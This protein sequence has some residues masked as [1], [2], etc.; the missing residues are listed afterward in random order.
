LL[1]S[2]HTDN[3]LVGTLLEKLGCLRD[4]G[5]SEWVVYLC[6][7]VAAFDGSALLTALP[8]FS[9]PPAIDDLDAWALPA[10]TNVAAPFGATL[11]PSPTGFDLIAFR[12]SA[13]TAFD[14][15][16]VGAAPVVHLTW[17]FGL[18][19]PLLL[20]D[21][22]APLP[23]PLFLVKHVDGWGGALKLHDAPLVL[24]TGDRLS[25]TA[26]RRSI[27]RLPRGALRFECRFT[28]PLSLSYFGAGL[29][30]L[31]VDTASINVGFGDSAT[32]LD[33]T[34]I[35]IYL[36]DPAPPHAW[37]N[38][39]V[40]M[41]PIT[42]PVADSLP[43]LV[44][45]TSPANAGA[46]VAGQPVPPPLV[47]GL[48]LA[49][50]GW[51]DTGGA[52]G[53]LTGPPLLQFEPNTPIPSTSEIR[54]GLVFNPAI[55]DDPTTRV[56]DPS[57]FPGL[58][59]LVD[60]Q[61]RFSQIVGADL[62]LSDLVGPGAGIGL[63]LSSLPLQRIGLQ[64]TAG[65]QVI[66]PVGVTVGGGP[67]G[68]LAVVLCLELDRGSFR[69]LT[70][71]RRISFYLMPDRDDHRIQVLDLKALAIGIPT[72]DDV[73]F[74][75]LAPSGTIDAD[76]FLDSVTA[77]F[78]LLDR[79]TV[80]VPRLK[81]WIIFPGV[82]PVEVEGNNA[83]NSGLDQRL[84]L[85]LA[86]FDVGAYQRDH[87]LAGIP[88]ALLA[89]GREGITFQA[90]LAT[91]QSISLLDAT[92]SLR[93]VELRALPHAANDPNDASE[94][95]FI[96]NRI[97]KAK[98]FFEVD[99]PG[100][101]NV[102]IT[103][104]LELRPSQRGHAPE[105]VA[106]FDVQD[107][108]PPITGKLS[109]G[110]LRAQLTRVCPRLSWDNGQWSVSMPAW[111]YFSVADGVD[112][113]AAGT[114][115][116]EAKLTFEALDLVT[117][118]SESVQLSLAKRNPA[119]NFALLGGKLRCRIRELALDWTLGSNRSLTIDCH[120]VSFDVASE[121]G[122]SVGFDTGRLQFTI[123]PGLHMSAIFSE[124]I[125]LHVALS[126]TFAFV[127]QAIYNRPSA[128]IP[129]GEI[130]ARGS[131]GVGGIDVT[132]ILALA[133]VKKRG[134]ARQLAVVVGGGEVV[135]KQ[136]APVLSV[137][138]FLVGIAVNYRLKGISAHPN[139]TELVRNIDQLDPENMANWVLVFDDGIYAAVF[140]KAI[141]T[142]TVTTPEVTNAYVATPLVSVDTHL[143]FLGA[144]RLWISA[145][146]DFA[147][148]N[149]DRPVLVGGVAFLPREK[150]LTLHLET[151]PHPAVQNNPQ[152]ELILS[153]AQGTLDFTV[154]SRLTDYQVHVDY[155]G[156]FFD[157]QMRFQG[158]FR[159]ALFD[160][161]VL[162]R[163][164]FTVSGSYR[165]QFSAGSAGID[166]DAE[167][168]ATADFRS[169]I[170][171]RGITAY[172][173][174]N[175]TLSVSVSGYM[176][177]QVLAWV[178]KQVKKL[179][180]WITRR[181]QEIQISRISGTF[182]ANVRFH[183]NAGMRSD[184]ATGFAGNVEIGGCLCGHDFGISVGFE[185]NP[186]AVNQALATLAAFESRL[187]KA[188]ADISGGARP[189][190]A[191]VSL[192]LSAAPSEQGRWTVNTAHH[193]RNKV[194]E[195][196]YLV[197]PL[198]FSKW[199]LSAITNVD[200]HTP[201]DVLPVSDFI[202]AIRFYDERDVL[203]HELYP[204][205]QW[206][207]RRQ[208]PAVAAAV[209]NVRRAEVAFL[210][211]AGDAI[212]APNERIV[213]DPRLESR[214][215]V[216][217]READRL[218]FPDYAAPARFASLD[219]L[220]GDP[221]ASGWDEIV[222]FEQLRLLA[223]QAIL[224]Q[225]DD[226]DE[227]QELESARA[228]LLFG[229]QDVLQGM[230][231]DPAQF[232][233]VSLAPRTN[234]GATITQELGL[235]ARLPSSTTV[236][237]I[238]VFRTAATTETLV[239]E[240]DTSST[241]SAAHVGAIR[242][243]PWGLDL[244]AADPSQPQAQP[245]I[246]GSVVLQ[247]P[248]FLP[249]ALLQASDPNVANLGPI[250]IYR[251]LP[252]EEPALI[253][254]GKRARVRRWLWQ[255]DQEPPVLYSFP[256]P[257]I[258]G[259]RFPYDQTGFIDRRILAGRTPIRYLF[260][261]FDNRGRL[262]ASGEWSPVR[263]FIPDT[264]NLPSN[265]YVVVAAQ[266]LIPEDRPPRADG[267][268]ERLSVALCTLVGGV[269]R[270]VE[271]TA[272]QIELYADEKD[273]LQ[274][275]F[276]TG[277]EFG[278]PPAH[279]AGFL[280]DVPAAPRA[281]SIIGKVRLISL[282]DD[283]RG[284]G[285]F[286]LDRGDLD[287]H[288]S[289]R[290]FVRLATRND[291]VLALPTDVGLVRTRD[292][293]AQTEK[294][295][296]ARTL[297]WPAVIAP[298]GCIE[299][300]GFSADPVVFMGSNWVRVNWEPPA[301]FTGGGEVI[302]VDRDDP[303]VIL[304]QRYELFD[305]GSFGASQRDFAAAAGWTLDVCDF[306][307][308][309]P[310][311]PTLPGGG[312][313]DPLAYY[314]D[315]GVLAGRPIVRDLDPQ[316]PNTAAAALATH[317]ALAS[318]QR[319]WQE[320]YRLAIAYLKSWTAFVRSPLNCGAPSIQ[321]LSAALPGLTSA[322]IVGVQ[323]TAIN[324]ADAPED[325]ATNMAGRGAGVQQ[326]LQALRALYERLRTEQFASMSITSDA[327]ATRFIDVLAL[328]KPGTAILKQRWNYAVQLLV[329]RRPDPLR[330]VPVAGTADGLINAALF[331][332]L[333]DNYADPATWP[334]DT[335]PST[336]LES[337]FVFDDQNFDV[338]GDRAALVFGQFLQT[339]Y[340]AITSTSDPYKTLLARAVPRASGPSEFLDDWQELLKPRKTT[341]V[342]RPHHSASV[343]PDSNGLV[344]LVP[345]D[346]A[347]FRPDYV[348]DGD[349]ITLAEVTPGGGS[350]P[351]QFAVRWHR[352]EQ[353]AKGIAHL[354]NFFER[355]GFST[356]LGAQDAVGNAVAPPSL[357]ASLPDTVPL[358]HQRL[359]C[360]GT[361]PY[362]F[363]PEQPRATYDF[364]SVA[365]VPDLFLTKLL[366]LL[367]PMSS[368]QLPAPA[369]DTRY[370]EIVAW[371]DLRQITLPSD[372]EAA[373]RIVYA[374]AEVAQLV[375][376][377]RDLPVPPGKLVHVDRR[378]TSPAPM[379]GGTGATVVIPVPD[380]W[381]HRIDVLLAPLSRY[382]RLQ[383]W[384]DRDRRIEIP[385]A[386]F[387]TR[388]HP[389]TLRP[390]LMLTDDSD[391]ARA[392]R[393]AMTPIVFGYPHRTRIQFLYR[394]S[395][396][397]FRS[398]V[399]RIAET[400]TGHEATDARF[401]FAPVDQPAGDLRRWEL[402]LDGVQPFTGSSIDPGLVWR[403]PLPEGTPKFPQALPG[404]RFVSLDHLPHCFAYQMVVSESFHQNEPVAAPSAWALEMMT[405][406][407][408]LLAYHQP[409]LSVSTAGAPTLTYTF[410]FVLTQHA[411][412]LTLLETS[413]VPPDLAG[414]RL[415]ARTPVTGSLS[416]LPI[417]Q[418][419]DLAMGFRV[420]YKY[421]GNGD[422]AR[423]EA[424]VVAAAVSLPWHP[425]YQLPPG[426]NGNVGDPPP[427]AMVQSY[428][429]QFVLA[430]AAPGDPL[431]V[432]IQ[433]QGTAAVPTSYLIQFTAHV[434]GTGTYFI[435][436]TRFRAQALRSDAEADAIVDFRQ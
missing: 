411:E 189:A 222:R 96:D 79:T 211:T 65:G 283:P 317:L 420:Y 168:H 271:L 208:D 436:P 291:D 1:T 165:R 55:F 178:E 115:K 361:A 404:E 123:D 201:L 412:H 299:K 140:G 413:N 75:S 154:T 269:A 56:A 196:H 83:G 322:V 360:A 284:P 230:A 17:S 405:R 48:K 3:A 132:V 255:P 103:G 333:H 87:P 394:I 146:I 52:P 378:A 325:R 232:A 198:R 429:G 363:L 134:G 399:N 332:T 392:I 265:L 90:R 88:N 174:V 414:A 97:V 20:G 315:P 326:K 172:A 280:D 417:T 215:R 323:T 267:R 45:P 435:D 307:Q 228:N 101:E 15:G 279:P 297:E 171:T 309:A 340:D 383:Q 175:Q 60:I 330:A 50:L 390:C 188:I 128:E 233:S 422:G 53:P 368:A 153:G 127:G 433:Y 6:P 352:D 91:E 113:S 42:L 403:T 182:T 304:R 285:L 281:E 430:G 293:L 122:L 268:D 428:N 85:N 218:V 344:S 406:R 130:R 199:Y 150:E 27:L 125:T 389:V 38:F 355:M 266:D 104:A 63:S 105:I 133:V 170:E 135:N 13:P 89:V 152:L 30:R 117:L 57:Q 54:G 276:Y 364:I 226:S 221:G 397:G 427:Q 301:G 143:R 324:M 34:C 44:M 184:G 345:T 76:G 58:A 382:E 320:I 328:A 107:T 365:I 434:D 78:V 277:D 202:S 262:L 149:L 210:Q 81:P 421:P 275:G 169:L 62:D 19:L 33:S 14:L 274:S 216:F 25:D 139:A 305:A 74:Q 388:A 145:S 314:I 183:G 147:Q 67:L 310:T 373:R 106:T 77:Q 160:D 10:G 82:L 321:A 116:E 69:V 227:V 126:P 35:S 229:L 219:E 366:A 329:A 351:P 2:A 248:L 357:I 197:L 243:L 224:L 200:D 426:A 398:F 418:L 64:R 231:A 370:Q 157:V 138:S 180:K 39:Q 110:F 195:T 415:V 193:T 129:Y 294:V 159:V 369:S 342:A 407:P 372:V 341:L 203:V 86:P 240:I 353:V 423:G 380:R 225:G 387:D 205:W 316:T 22:P 247:L 273:T 371:L 401:A 71:K 350:G 347:S 93:A 118:H 259:D 212:A 36:H 298:S 156:T 334:G 374:L 11:T 21:E 313:A 278:T 70:R 9:T 254:Q 409:V 161:A 206:Y 12:P 148:Q 346:L 292:E 258:H 356:D 396:Y 114:F 72:G 136:L 94:V 167:F 376:R 166:F 234:T 32:P 100:F 239:A 287:P 395:D 385:W 425:S 108:D 4:G 41:P 185:I 424:Y 354:F 158:G 272:R 331:Q 408:R 163:A 179:L 8:D 102:S 306:Q 246:L 214:S 95:V 213:R 257:F 92:P 68:R 177:I 120:D 402:V 336:P 7:F 349:T 31:V 111:G 220:L 142:S 187:D 252:G 416:A 338:T 242:A 318:S 337:T 98:V 250:D 61:S 37:L 264:Q 391:T 23:D 410:T 308:L 359:V 59:S 393:A 173:L 28:E 209:A 300:S 335:F 253:A 109:S 432:S 235:I 217:W 24:A 26:S 286:T 431:W 186:D 296:V 49:L 99:L 66:I 303:N 181:E 141:L 144:G 400:R 339:V 270:R 192:A 73:D 244:V 261:A 176:E 343:K 379:P 29:C 319:H 348:F 237:T 311:P 5:N 302:L 312:P 375:L 282:A 358:F 191:A 263:L 295:Q 18:R 137:Y 327:S 46:P 124:S 151:R 190:P 121:A 51:A 367:E 384:L 290:F 155:Q 194:D 377:A 119:V 245:G 43:S 207:P 236:K 256:E 47:F 260:D 238:R 40:E 362:S 289:Y 204:F 164:G 131:V 112:S 251:Q 386:E 288:N 80:T 162:S 249:D 223:D 419:P 16:T 84:Q 241:A 381:G